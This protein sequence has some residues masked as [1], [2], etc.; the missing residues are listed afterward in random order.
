MPTVISR[1][2][3][4][5]LVLLAIVTVAAALWFVSPGFPR[6]DLAALQRLSSGWISVT[7]VASG[8]FGVMQLAV[9]LGLGGQRLE[10]L[11]WRRDALWPALLATAL[12]WA[13]MQSGTVVAAWASGIAPVLD[14]AWHGSMGNALGPLLAQLLGTAL[15]EETVFR[16]YLW[17][18]LSAWL[19]GGRRGAWL[20]AFASQLAFAL[21]HIPI[22]L[23]QGAGVGEV[24]GMMLMLFLT[25]LVFVLIYAATRNL[26]I[27]VGVHALGN[28]PTLIF[29]PQ[30]PAP[31]MLLLAGALAIACGL[32][33]RRRRLPHGGQ[34]GPWQAHPTA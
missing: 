31:T 1:S 19:G 26:F 23:Y 30:G 28:A 4:I 16:G 32:W 24:A 34:A 29:E 8:T 9:I 6:S 17:P 21:L 25:G 27:A 18:Q 33:V 14:E 22:L 13:L 12:L 2:P 10:A 15:M 3:V 7:L 11:G 5:A 20:G